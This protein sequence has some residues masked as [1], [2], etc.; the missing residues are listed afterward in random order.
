MQPS[1]PRTT[2]SRTAR[3]L[4]LDSPA[5]Y[6]PKALGFDFDGA[7]FSHVGDRVTFQVLLASFGLEQE[8]GRI[9]LAALVHYLDVGGLPVPEAAGFEA[10]LAG[11]RANCPDDDA[12]LAAST[13]VLDAL[14]RRFADALGM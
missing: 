8:P 5:D 10:V 12:L 3:F 6:P 11:L 14:Q 4:W 7:P 13:P 9:R 2:T 1:G